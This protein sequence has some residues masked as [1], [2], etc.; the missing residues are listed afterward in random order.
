MLLPGK[1]EHKWVFV[2][3]SSFLCC[4]QQFFLLADSHLGDGNSALFIITP[5]DVGH[6]NSSIILKWYKALFARIMARTTPLEKFSLVQG[7]WRASLPLLKQAF[8]KR[9]RKC[10]WVGLVS[11]TQV[12]NSIALMS[13]ERRGFGGKNWLLITTVSE[14]W[15]KR[16][17]KNILGSLLYDV[18]PSSSLLLFARPQESSTRFSRF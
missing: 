17:P 16:W 5:W 9:R 6:N 13:P 3:K 11:K 7:W 12:E 10:C 18:L 2:W 1:K 8:Q 4:L 15:G 14:I